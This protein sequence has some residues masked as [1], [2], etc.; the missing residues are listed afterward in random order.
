MYEKPYQVRAHLYHK[1][2][3]HKK[4]IE[5]SKTKDT[6]I[7]AKKQF[8]KNIESNELENHTEGFPFSFKLACPNN[9]DKTYFFQMFKG[10]Q[11]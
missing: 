1:N 7:P 4:K 3:M 9:C 11:N 2:V 10:F 6:D 8:L 5:I